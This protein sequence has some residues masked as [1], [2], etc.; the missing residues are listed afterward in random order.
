MQKIQHGVTMQLMPQ[1]CGYRCIVTDNLGNNVDWII[2]AQT[3]SD[4]TT[5][6]ESHLNSAIHYL[7]G[8][9]V[10]SDFLD[11]VEES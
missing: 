8:F 1:P 9:I 2:D 4:A 6:A 7:R 3:M 10:L 11:R 5:K